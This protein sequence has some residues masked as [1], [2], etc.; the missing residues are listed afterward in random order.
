MFCYALIF[1]LS[2]GGQMWK[3][4]WIGTKSEQTQTYN[5]LKIINF[6]QNHGDSQELP[7]SQ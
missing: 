4:G 6:Q 2:G 5:Q 3:L 7:L 1:V